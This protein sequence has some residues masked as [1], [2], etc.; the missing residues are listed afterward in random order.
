MPASTFH[1]FLS[2]HH[3]GRYPSYNIVLHAP[4]VV[5]CL[6]V[7]SLFCLRLLP[8][9]CLILAIYSACSYCGC[10]AFYWCGCSFCSCFCYFSQLE[11][12]LFCLYSY[13][14]FL[15]APSAVVLPA[16]TWLFCLLLLFVSCL[17]LLRLF[18]LLWLWLFF[19]LLLFVSCLL[20]LHLFCLLWLWLVVLP[21]VAVLPATAVAVLPAYSVAFLPILT[22]FVCWSNYD[23]FAC[24]CSC[25]SPPCF[26]VVG[27]FT[28]DVVV[29]CL[30]HLLMICF[31]LL[32]FYPVL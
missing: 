26:S 10:S 11:L 30:F 29:V 25:N 5:F 28:T 24:S 16:A 31:L 13:S 18:C 21:T 19:L 2:M 1:L 23:C 12:W 22:V 27:M 32:L 17:L 15:P 3:G 14:C 4:T 7:L 9:F 20:L 6:L 8:L